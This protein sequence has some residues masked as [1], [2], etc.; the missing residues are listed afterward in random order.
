MYLP[1]FNILGIGLLNSLLITN[2]SPVSQLV[3]FPSTL[4]LSLNIPW[5][6]HPSIAMQAQCIKGIQRVRKMWR[7]YM[8][9]E[10]DRQSL[11]VQG[12]NLRGRQIPLHLQNPHNPSRYQP[13]TIRIKIKNVPL[14]ADDGQ[15]DRALAMEGCEIQGIFR[16]SVLL[17]IHVDSPYL[18]HTL[19]PLYTLG[20]H[21]IAYGLINFDIC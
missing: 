6:S 21:F 14:S 2:L 4:S 13:D 9:N 17:I 10:E 12:I 15:I 11:L 19:N 8:D 7:I 5:I 16:L 20:L 3:S 1:I 18:A